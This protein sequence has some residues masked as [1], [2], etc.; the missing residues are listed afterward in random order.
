M[1][2]GSEVMVLIVP[3]YRAGVDIGLSPWLHISQLCPGTTHHGRSAAV[4]ISRVALFIALLLLPSGCSRDVDLGAFASQPL[5]V[6]S[7]SG[8]T[9]TGERH[10]SPSSKEH[11][12][13]VRWAEQHK[14]GWSRSYVSYAP[15]GIMV[16]GTNFSLNVHSSGVIL[17]ING[18]G[19]YER[20]APASDFS[21][22]TE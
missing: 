4:I 16:R 17:N 11:G 10:V 6:L 14:T 18:K 7:Y 5:T 20:N 12:L 9:N 2:S 1:E 8:G 15:G 21:F 22:L 13:L 3:N 19:Q